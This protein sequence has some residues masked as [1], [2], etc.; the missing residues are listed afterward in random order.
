MVLYECVQKPRKITTDPKLELIR[1]L[2]A[3]RA[4]GLFPLH[5]CDLDDL[6]TITRDAPLG[7]G[8]GE[9]SCIAVAYR[10]VTIGVMT[11]EKKARRFAE[12]QLRL[13]VETT[14]RLY[15]WLHYHMYLSDGDH[16]EVITEHEKHEERPLTRFFEE[17]YEAALHHRLYKSKHLKG[18]DPADEL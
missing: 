13:V 9:L 14:P 6:A 17:G 8:S 16:S 1:R 4:E 10:T 12:Q 3:A 7:L 11:D 18:D 5:N 15:A 2:Y